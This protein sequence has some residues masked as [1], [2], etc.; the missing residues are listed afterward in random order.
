MRSRPKLVIVIFLTLSALVLKA[1]DQKTSSDKPSPTF[2][3][4]TELVLVPTVVTDKSGQHVSGLTKEDFQVLDQRR[5]QEIKV[6][7]EITTSSGQPQAK[8]SI[9][10]GEFSNY[11]NAGTLDSP[12]RVTIIVFD[13]V[14]MPTLKQQSARKALLQFL[15][16]TASANEPT[17]VY[18]ISRKGVSVIS[19]FTTDPKVLAEALT[20]LKTGHET[21]VSG[22]ERTMH[23]GIEGGGAV[24]PNMMN[25]MV[26]TST[27]G[28]KMASILLALEQLDNQLQLNI[29]SMERRFAV[30][31]TLDAMHEIA[32][33]CAAI[34]GRKSLLWVGGGFPFD[35]SPNDMML[36]PGA[37]PTI[38]SGRS[39]LDQVLS[40]YLRVWRDLN[41]AQVS[42][43]PI[44]VRGMYD[45]GLLGPNVRNTDGQYQ[46]WSRFQQQQMYD[47]E[48]AFAQATGGKP[49]YG[50]N[51]L[52][53]GFEQATNDSSHYYLIGYYIKPE[54]AA[55]IQWHEVQVKPLRKGIDIRARGGYFYRPTA[56]DLQQSRQHDLS[57][58]LLSPIDFTAIPVT[59]RWKQKSPVASGNQNVAFEI[60]MPAD[61]AAINE[62]DNNHLMS[63]IIVQAKKLDGTPV[64]QPLSRTMDAHLNPAQVQQVKEHGL[65]YANNIELPKGDYLVRFVVRD[66]LNGHMGSVTAP[67][68]VE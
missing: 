10:N 21:I 7:E 11:V 6:F 38:P 23:E 52:K 31:Y 1:S 63:D 66:G 35:V 50:S 28:G 18:S 37:A 64:G 60:V 53:A 65:T 12:R 32:Q 8:S 36:D 3:S 40:L 42:I 2:T 59:V 20:K 19:D 62:V 41:D 67:L 34:P 22:M 46:R 47:T 57:A 14:N 68:K 4:Q 43:Y 25:A 13:L 29:S 9:V 5:P 55:K 16:E 49:Y 54:N 24:S 27:E 26:S 56:A 17:A 58:G 45:P 39:G 30:D 61:F 15:S 48:R 44:D 51:D 33:A